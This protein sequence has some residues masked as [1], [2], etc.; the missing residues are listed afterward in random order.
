MRLPVP[1]LEDDDTLASPLRHVGR[2][3]LFGVA[4]EPV[5]ADLSGAAALL[6]HDVAGAVL[7]D[8][9]VVVVV[10]AEE[11]GDA[12]AYRDTDVD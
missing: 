10:A 6:A 7:A 1:A 2:Q 12:A 11:G 5:A 9:A 4:G 3:R 8:A